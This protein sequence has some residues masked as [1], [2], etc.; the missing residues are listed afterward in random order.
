MAHSS[1]TA[2]IVWGF[3]RA[4]LAVYASKNV[5]STPPRTQWPFNHPS[6][7][8]EEDWSAVSGVVEDDLGAPIARQVYVVDFARKIVHGPTTS[9]ATTGAYSVKVP[10]T[11][12]VAVIKLDSS[13]NA[14]IF[15]R[16]VPV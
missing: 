16:V 13:E 1:Y 10:W 14:E 2:S 3:G 12:E 6:K 15:D 11:D 9:N 7:P 5:T 8:W 4:P